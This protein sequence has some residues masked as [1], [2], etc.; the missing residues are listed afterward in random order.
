MPAL[1]ATRFNA[2]LSRVYKNLREQGKKAKVAL[3][4]VIRKLIILANTLICEN[5]EW[6]E[7][8]P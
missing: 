2:Q 7:I 3:V 8:K 5:R 1:V 4:A 6:S